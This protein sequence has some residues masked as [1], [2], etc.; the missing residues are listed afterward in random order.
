MLKGII[1]PEDLVEKLCDKFAES[2]V[3]GDNTYVP[4]DEEVAA[5]HTYR[6]A[7]RILAGE[8]PRGGWGELPVWYD[9]LMS[10]RFGGSSE[11][12]GRFG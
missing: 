9:D 7:V 5:R 10:N 3:L 11:N 12:D 6:R 1:Q 8:D 2:L 4:T